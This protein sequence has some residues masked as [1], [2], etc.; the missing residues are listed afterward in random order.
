[1]KWNFLRLSS[2]LI[3]LTLLI[4]SHNIFAQQ[5]KI[6]KPANW[7]NT[8]I[9]EQPKHSDI[10]KVRD[11]TL[12]LLLD[13]QSYIPSRQKQ[14]RYTR[15]VMKALNQSGVDYISQL[16]L[17]FDP[18]YES[19]TLN[20]L[21]II[22]N[23]E[24]IDKL[25]S[26]RM[27]VIQGESE[28]A[29]R[30]YNGSLSLNI[31]IDDMRSGDILDYSYTVAGSNPIYANKF[32]TRRTL[33]WSVPVV[34]QNM[35]VLWGKQTPL[36]INTINGTADIQETLN[37][38]GKDYS[39]TLFEEP[40]LE[41]NSQT[42][43]W[44]DPYTQ[45]YF[46]EF[47]DWGQVVNWAYPLYQSAI[48]TPNSILDVAEEIKAKHTKT[49]DKIAAALRF[50]QDEVRYLGLEMGTNSHQPTS[51]SETLSLRYGD[52]KDKTVLLISLLKAMDIEAFPALVDTEE[53]KRLKELPPSA[54]VFNHVIVTLKQNGKRYWLDPTVSYQRGTLEY[55]AQPDYGYALIIDKGETTLTSMAQKPVHTNV[56]VEDNFFIAEKVSEPS[57]FET[58]YTYAEFE[59]INRRSS[60]ASSGLNSVAKSY[61]EYYQGFLNGLSI[62]EAMTISEQEQTGKL[63][64]KESYLISEFW[65]KTDEGYEASFYAN[66]IQ[67]SVY[68]PKQVN[69]TDPLYFGYP[70]IIN[71][72]IKL[73]FAEKGWGFDSDQEEIDNDYFNL[74][75]T[76]EFNDNVLTLSYDY[77]AKQDHIKAAQID[78]YLAQRKKLISATHYPILKYAETTETPQT[79]ADVL[80][81]FGY[82]WL[83]YVLAG[84]ILVL[85]FFFAD[86]RLESAKK[87]KFEDS[88]FYAVSVSKFIIYSI[89]SLGIFVNYWSYRNFKAIKER[90]N[91]SIMPIARGIFAF[92]WY[93]PL[94]LALAE[95][96]QQQ[97]NKNRVMPNWTALTLWLMVLASVFAYRMD[98]YATIVI[99]IMPFLW[100][101]LVSYIEQTDTSKEALHYNSYW[102]IRQYLISLAFAPL[103]FLGV[104]QEVNILPNAAIIKGDS[105]W[106]YQVHF[107]KRNRL[108]PE[109]EEI[110]YF[111]SDAVFDYREDGNGITE[112]YIFSYYKNDDGRLESDLSHFKDIEKIET[113]YGKTKLD[114]TSIKV[115]KTDGSDFLLIVGRLNKQ[116]KVLV[117]QI[118]LRITANK[119]R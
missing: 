7:V 52:C 54:S 49:S 114:N 50:S 51:A 20:S 41:Q 89:L 104:L 72:T 38:Y 90:D 71:T 47:D 106:S 45:V 110:L 58:Q 57:R 82:S 119:V 8:H 53:T 27:T 40:L 79:T 102:R 4:F 73:H 87:V 65:E 21:T 13:N 69:R 56:S 118:N 11:G 1:M 43:T 67:N 107:L 93:Y 42:P 61:F 77:Y 37:K 23:N 75:T 103:L 46:S 86:W 88:P 95:H 63:I 78:D 3:A 12:Y 36:H 94:Y 5:Y 24:R 25:G 17:D 59:A 115:I 108:T 105:L 32:S 100:L 14:Q 68:E 116:D 97:L 113:T 64:T 9:I 26:A 101:P 31:I 35:R 99:C 10:T 30:I 33:N 18:S 48:E 112:N 80:D 76:T 44:Y 22:R 62:N 15:L 19:L 34:Q 6:D 92:L 29:D 74:K 16:N 60:I 111:Y 39:I 84:Y 2:W 96:S 28:L 83:K 55:L 117:E 91:S 98:E 81:S 70:N 85:I 109:N 66:E